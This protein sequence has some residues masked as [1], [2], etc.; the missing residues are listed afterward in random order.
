MNWQ[1]PLS[2]I[3]YSEQ[4]FAAVEQVLRSKWLSMGQVT[5]QF[6]QAAAA[7]FETRHAFAVANGTTALHLAYA[8]LGMGPGD[9]VILPSLTFVATASAV[10]YTGATPVFADIIALDD[11][12]ISPEQIESRIT[13]RTRAIVVMHYGGYPCD[14]ETI[15]EIAS[16]HSL[17]VVEDAAHA[18]GTVYNGR[19]A[20]TLGDVGCFSFF[21][22]KNLVTGE[23]GL[24]VT[25]RDDLA[26]RIRLMRSHGMTTLTWDRHH[27]HAHSYDVTT[28]GYNYRLDEIRSTLGLTQLEKL[29]INNRRRKE[30]TDVYR[31]E[32]ADAQGILLPFMNHQGRSACHLCPVLLDDGIDRGAFIDRM[33]AAGVQTSIHYPPIHTFSYYRQRFNYELGLLPLTEEAGRREVTLPLFSGMTEAQVQFVVQV[34]RASIG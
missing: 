7:Y 28:L 34:A 11:L 32:L 29:D 15:L 2:D 18:P 13:P 27:G 19:K 1:V 25:A 24:V 20:G 16:Q 5:Q 31:Q 22:N 9:E 26:E 6:E 14:M 23:G 12:T 33:R 21:A 17:A 3:D 4:E 30:I 8:A 10:L